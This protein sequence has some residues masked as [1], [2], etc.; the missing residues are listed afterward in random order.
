MG[1]LSH[2]IFNLKGLGR[3][4]IRPFKFLNKQKRME[5]L[6]DR[7]KDRRDDRGIMIRN[8]L[9]KRLQQFENAQLLVE[10]FNTYLKKRMFKAER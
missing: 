2:T 1:N 3:F 8:E 9:E 7:F 5:K 10:D 4:L 6:V